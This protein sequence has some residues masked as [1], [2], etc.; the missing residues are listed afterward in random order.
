M[1]DITTLFLAI[2]ILF[3]VFNNHITA[4]R[5]SVLEEEMEKQKGENHEQKTIRNNATNGNDR[6]RD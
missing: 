5:L 4:N 3:I 6:R 1:T 2:S